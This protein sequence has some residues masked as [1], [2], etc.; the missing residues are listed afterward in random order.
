MFSRRICCRSLVGCD[1][2]DISLLGFPLALAGAILSIL[3]ALDNNLFHHHRR[4]MLLWMLSNPLL[5]IWAVG[6]M[7]GLWADGLGLAFIAGMYLLY[8]FSN[9]Y[10][11][12]RYRRGKA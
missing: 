3:G 1:S 9:A 2:V 7:L 6:M 8:I 10:G 12:L 5:F 4:A 11:I